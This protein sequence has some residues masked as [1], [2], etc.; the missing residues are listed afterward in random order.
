M[1]GF[2]LARF[3]EGERAE[4]L[5][6]HIHDTVLKAEACPGRAAVAARLTTGDGGA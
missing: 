2:R 4:W 3:E 1:Q 5:C 6:P